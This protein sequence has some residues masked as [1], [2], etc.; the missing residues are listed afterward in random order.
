MLANWMYL[1][2]FELQIK[3][4]IFKFKLG[5]LRKS[6][7]QITEKLNLS[8][9]YSTFKIFYFDSK[10]ILCQTSDVII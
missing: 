9:V 1:L 6:S 4:K 5:Q 8:R 10:K 7:E 3:L 2:I